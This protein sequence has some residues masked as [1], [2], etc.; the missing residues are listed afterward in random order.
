MTEATLETVLPRLKARLARRVREHH[1]PGAAV[2]VV[3]GEDLIW[4]SGLGFADVPSR[5]APD[6]HTLYRVASI[7]KTVTATAIMQLR[8]EGKLRLDDPIVRHLPEFASVRS[9]HGEI[10]DVTVRRL[11]SHRSGLITEGPFS[12]WDT[13]DFPAMDEVIAK[14]A[15]SELAIAPDTAAKYSNL[16]FALLGEVVARLSGQPYEEYVHAGIFGPLGM[17][18]STFAPDESLR[19]RL[20]TGYDPHPFED[21]PAPAGHTST[22]GIT[23]AAGLYTT[24]HNLAR[25]IALQFRTGER[26]REGAQVPAGRT[27]EEMQRPQ[28]IDL[29]WTMA[30]CLGW[31]AQRRGEQVFHGHGGSIHGFITQVLFSVPRRAGVI[32][33]TNEGRHGAANTMAV[34]ALEMVLAALP[35]DESPEE[36][37]SPVPTPP[38]LRPYLG[39]YE[40]WRGGIVQVECRDGRLMLGVPPGTVQSL[41]APAPLE[42]TEQPHVFRV[43]AGRG[44]GELLTFTAGTDGSVTGFL[45]AGFQYSR[46]VR[47]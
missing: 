33:L 6:A 40:F 18:E 42:A 26:S 23:A 7:T 13:L 15:E 22:R 47:A 2:G 3:R 34:E 28:D 10:D 4:S 19:A 32:V 43:G 12:Y 24:V 41:H 11:L 8:D 25:W 35:E 45:L 16:A 20:A 27:L 21:E 46:L 38:E 44:A 36:W 14:L 29:T 31:M 1:L 39:H 30:R 37:S 17:A 9:R 5:R